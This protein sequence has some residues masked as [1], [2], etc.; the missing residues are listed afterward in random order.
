VKR[1]G[2]FGPPTVA[3]TIGGVCVPYF[4]SD[5]ALISLTTFSVLLSQ[6]E[7]LQFFHDDWYFVTVSPQDLSAYFAPSN[8]HWSTVP[9]IV[10]RLLLGVFGLATHVP[11]Q[12]LMLV[13]HLA[14][15]ALVF[16]IARR[17]S[18]DLLAAAAALLVLVMGFGSDDFV[19]C[20][21]GQFAAS[22][23]FGLLALDLLDQSPVAWRT[24]L[25]SG[26]LVLSLAASGMGVAFVVAALV[27]AG[28]RRDPLGIAAASLPLLIFV[29][30]FRLLDQ[31]GADTAVPLTPG[32][33]WAVVQFIGYGIAATGASA[34]GAGTRFG[35][36]PLVVS[37][38]GLAAITG[39]G[40]T[41]S[42]IAWVLSP[43]AGIVAEFGSIGLV[44]VQGFG[45]A[46]A[47]T[48]R[49]MYVSV[50]LLTLLVSASVSSLRCRLPWRIVLSGALAVALIG[51]M[52]S[53]AGAVAYWRDK[54]ATEDIVLATLNAIQNSPTPD[55]T[56]LADA[57]DAPS[58][59]VA[60]FYAAERRFGSIGDLPPFGV[61]A[62][63]QPEVV[64]TV[65]RTVFAS[66][67]VLSKATVISNCVD[68]EPLP[69]ELLL[70]PGARLELQVE[71]S[72]L[73][74]VALG[75]LRSPQP[76]RSFS[77]STGIWVLKAPTVRLPSFIWNVTI[78]A[79]YDASVFAC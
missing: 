25:T 79:G 51:N 18:G 47:G 65:L 22:V 68:R 60:A 15:V 52:A 71:G 57:N 41:R 34:A 50:V 49:Y 67:V 69:S 24:L 63:Q 54:S 64:D 23:M 46:E 11:E 62:A 74:G 72:G 40:V 48:N 5:L 7:H 37:V 4:R 8:G 21:S 78:S 14:V 10:Y 58:V 66:S 55:Q 3:E 26:A 75:W 16:R 33:I 12:V 59:Q 28:L 30:W 20:C 19:Y 53:L 9:I 1:I 36:L 45:V 6:T 2:S 13:E 44:R 35:A 43:L 56:V 31:S 27:Q 70:P 76:A 17:R 61:A 42:P 39:V 29:A 77:V 38:L 73:L 32:G